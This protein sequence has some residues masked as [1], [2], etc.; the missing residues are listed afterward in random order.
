MINE[1]KRFWTASRKKKAKQVGLTQLQVSTMASIVQRET[2]KDDE[3]STIAG[4]YMNRYN[5]NWKLEADPTV[6][7]ACQDFS[8]RRVLKKHLQVDSPYNTYKYKGLPPGPI[9]IPSIATIESVL[10]FENHDYMYFCAKE[11]FSGYHNFAKS[12]A[13]HLVNARKYRKALRNRNKNS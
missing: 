5:N 10:N 7:F 4:V 2:A 3:K 6:I 8:I 11:D 9:C 12:Y 13:K 1:Y